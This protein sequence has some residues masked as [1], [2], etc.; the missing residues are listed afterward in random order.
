MALKND[1]D[2]DPFSFAFRVFRRL[3]HEP[4][5]G[6]SSAPIPLTSASS[7]DSLIATLLPT[8]LNFQANIEPIFRSSIY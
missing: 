3:V 5:P 2:R 6:F 7:V 1:R 8:F 4:L